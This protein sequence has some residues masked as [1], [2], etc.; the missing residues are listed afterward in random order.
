MSARDQVVAMADP[1]ALGAGSVGLFV[2]DVVYASSGIPLPVLLSQDVVDR[3]SDGR[4]GTPWADRAALMESVWETTSPAVRQPFAA[5]SATTAP[6]SVSGHL[7][8]SSTSVTSSCR[9]LV[10]Q[11]RLTP[12]PGATVGQGEEP[13]PPPGGAGEPDVPANGVCDSLTRPA[14]N[15]A[16]LLADYAGPGRAV[17]HCVGAMKASTGAMLASRFPYVTPSGV[18]GPCDGWPTQQLVDGGYTENTGLGTIVDLAPQWLSLVRAHN[19][20][21]LRGA[22][23][24]ELVIPIVVY[25]DNGT[26][27][28]LTAPTRKITSELLVPPVGKS[29][30]GF[31]QADTPALLQRA[32]ALADV[33]SLWDGSVPA[34]DAAQTVIRMWRPKPVL[35]VRQSTF[36]AV[37]APLGWVLSQDSIRTMDRALQQ[38]SEAVCTPARTAD[39]L[40]ARGFGSLHDALQLLRNN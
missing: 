25:L 6:G 37:T 33:P 9:M 10:S 19:T 4:D 15:S 7:I 32:G 35:V 2:R 14:P 3:Y 26:G 24:A 8:L 28:D 21:A 12:G 23:P 36:P 16:D 5:S 39:A 31:A 18:I 17:D 27:S 20:A 30:A 29:R 22:G 13:Q 34:T 38:Q 1:R 11:L 40:C